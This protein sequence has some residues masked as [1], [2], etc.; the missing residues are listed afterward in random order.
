MDTHT[1][2]H[3]LCLLMLLL[4]LLLSRL[5]R[6]VTASRGCQEGSGAGW[7]LLWRCWAGLAWPCWMSPAADRTAAQQCR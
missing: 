1:A 3:M 7:L 2:A 6:R 5:V 4:L